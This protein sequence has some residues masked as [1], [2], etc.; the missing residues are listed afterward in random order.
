D[1]A[2][3]GLL[4]SRDLGARLCGARVARLSMRASPPGGITANEN[5]HRRGR[6]RSD[7]A[8]G[9]CP[10]EGQVVVVVIEGRGAGAGAGRALRLAA[11]R[12]CVI[13]ARRAATTAAA[14]AEHDHLAHDDVGPV[15]DVALVVLGLAV[16]DATLDV[17][18]V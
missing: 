1:A 18:A 9:R 7:A 4:R 2:S 14:A 16:L 15:A 5:R 11:P 6:W 3:H 8:R 17:E 13:A 10:L 12:C